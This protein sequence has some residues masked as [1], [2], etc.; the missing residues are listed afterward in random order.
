M[1]EYNIKTFDLNRT[2]TVRFKDYGENIIPSLNFNEGH[3]CETR[4]RHL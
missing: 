4:S 3:L 2:G 1:M